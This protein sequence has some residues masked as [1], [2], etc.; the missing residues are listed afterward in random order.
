MQLTHSDGRAA[1]DDNDD[2]D[3]DDDEEEEEEEKEQCETTHLSPAQLKVLML[4]EDVKL[5]RVNSLT[6]SRTT[7][8]FSQ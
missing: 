8:A 5:C 7:A 4:F 2:D 6:I 3:D 1:A